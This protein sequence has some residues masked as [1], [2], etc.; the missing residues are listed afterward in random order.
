MAK[1]KKIKIE[2]L[3][4]ILK[5]INQDLTDVYDIDS[6]AEEVMDF[7]EGKVSDDLLNIMKEMLLGFSYEMQ[8]E[9]ADNLRDFALGQVIHT[10]GCMSADAVLKSCYEWIATEK[11]FRIL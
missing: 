9:I 1:K 5:V 2:E 6:D 8:L 11:G 7:M 10:T 3:E 4:L